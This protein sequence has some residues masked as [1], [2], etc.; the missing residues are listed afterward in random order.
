MSTDEGSVDETAVDGLARFVTSLDPGKK[1]KADD[2][3]VEDVSRR[4]RRILAERTQAGPENEYAAHTG[5]CFMLRFLLRAHGACR[6]KQV[7]A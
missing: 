2:D 5:A 1:R 3:G 4:K 7:A 6:L